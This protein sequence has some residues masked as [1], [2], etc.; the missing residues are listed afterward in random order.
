MK[1]KTPPKGRAGKQATPV[2]AYPILAA[3]RA[4]FILAD[5]TTREVSW[6]E[7]PSLPAANVQSVVEKAAR[8]NAGAIG[9]Y[10]YDLP[11]LVKL[12]ATLVAMAAAAVSLLGEAPTPTDD[13]NVHFA[14]TN[15]RDLLPDPF[16]R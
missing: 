8:D 4:K 12:Q 10:G 16:R 2:I 9:S 14:M 6:I 11:T 3:G 13:D 1:L 5:G 15:I 7:T